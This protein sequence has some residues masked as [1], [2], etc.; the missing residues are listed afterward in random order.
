MKRNITNAIKEYQKNFYNNESG[1]CALYLT[2][3][4]QV[5]SYCLEKY[6]D[7][8]PANLIFCALEAGI[9]IGYN[10]GKKDGKKEF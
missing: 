4:A 5:K 3:I 7:Q 6:G 9:M 8:N 10:A 2:D 1:K